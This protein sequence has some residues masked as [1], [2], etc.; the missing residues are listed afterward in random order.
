MLIEEYKYH[1]SKKL[2]YRTVFFLLIFITF[3][4]FSL[5]KNLTGF[6]IM[7]IVGLL[8]IGYNDLKYFDKLPQLVISKHGIQHKAQLIYW[9][10]IEYCMIEL[11]GNP[12]AKVGGLFWVLILK[13]ANKVVLESIK[14][15]CLNARKD[16]IEKDLDEIWL[17]IK[18]K[19]R[20]T[21]K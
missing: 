14:L 15:N 6:A 12:T 2:K 3:F 5:Y 16:R 19:K 11:K 1:I 7:S 4:I 20:I 9:D 18:N 13:D 10:K 8:I 17:L 21:Y